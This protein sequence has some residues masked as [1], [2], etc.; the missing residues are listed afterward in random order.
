[1]AYEMARGN[2]SAAEVFEKMTALVRVMADS[3][4]SGL[5]G[6]TYADRILPAQSLLFK[7]KMNQG[8][9]AG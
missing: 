9:T 8:Q 4:D 2:I 3:I 1:M 7:D 6:T 5:Q